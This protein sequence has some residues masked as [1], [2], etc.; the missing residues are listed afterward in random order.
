MEGI[1]VHINRWV[2]KEDVCERETG[3]D[4]VCVYYSAIN[5]N[6]ILS[7]AQTWINREYYAQWNKSEKDNYY[8]VSLICGI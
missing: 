3:G 8:V 7:F 6:E 5:K 2:D 4:C 1:Q